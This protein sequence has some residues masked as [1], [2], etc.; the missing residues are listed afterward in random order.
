LTQTFADED[1]EQLLWQKDENGRN[2]FMLAAG[3]NNSDGILESL[4]YFVQTLLTPEE[5]KRFLNETDK[6]EFSVLHLAVAFNNKAVIESLCRVI[7]N[8]L[9][10]EEQKIY[11]QKCGYVGNDIFHLAAYNSKNAEIFS[12]IW[13]CLSDVLSKDELK[14]LWQQRNDKGDNVFH[15]MT[16]NATENL[17]NEFLVFFTQ[18][19]SDEDRKQLLLM[20]NQDERNVFMIAA[21]IT[22]SDVVLEPLWSFAQKLLTP[23]EQKRF[24]NETDKLGLNA[25]HLAES[26]KN[27]TDRESIFRI[28]KNLLSV[29]EQKIYCSIESSAKAHTSSDNF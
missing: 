13:N 19:F 16:W 8:L 20:K 2:G 18:N 11:F 1:R 3:I 23:E 29:E 12:T 17:L 6:Q 22:T 24:L 7:K 25:L 28:I 15:V 21:C 10:V 26:L 4:W 5:Q 14:T 27:I 9:S